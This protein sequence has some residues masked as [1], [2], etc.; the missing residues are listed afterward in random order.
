MSR[1]PAPSGRGPSNDPPAQASVSQ[2]MT[3]HAEQ[4]SRFRLW[5]PAAVPPGLVER[6]LA[7]AWPGIT[8]SLLEQSAKSDTAAASAP[9]AEAD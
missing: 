4:G 3:C 9:S 6:A 1:D 5:I 8:T 7:S 2:N